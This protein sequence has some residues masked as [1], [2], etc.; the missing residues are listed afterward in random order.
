MCMYFVPLFIFRTSIFTGRA[1]IN[2]DTSLAHA[3][4]IDQLE[5][6]YIG[7]DLTLATAVSLISAVWCRHATSCPVWIGRLRLMT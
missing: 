5:I 2:E 4:N 1:E 7:V 3:F 6:T